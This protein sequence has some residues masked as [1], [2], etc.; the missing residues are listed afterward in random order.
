MKEDIKKDNNLSKP[1]DKGKTG[2]ESSDKSKSQQ[3]GKPNKRN[4]KFKGSKKKGNQ[5]SS[6]PSNDPSWYTINSEITKQV[7][8]IPFNVF[9]GVK[10][11]I[12]EA[13]TNKTQAQSVYATSMKVPGVMV[14]KY[15]PML[16]SGLSSKSVEITA[17]ALYQF[18]RHTNS[19]AKNYESA[20]LM[21]YILAM[22]SVYLA[23]HQLR[24]VL[25]LMNTYSLRNK[26]VPRA[27]L[28]A[29]ALDP[30]E[31]KN[32][33]LY[34]G[35]FNVLVA[36]ANSF[37]VPKDF[38]LFKRRAAMGTVVFSD[39]AE[40]PTQITVP[41]TDMVYVYTSTGYKTGGALVGVDYLRSTIDDTTS[42]PKG[43]IP[44]RVEGT[45]SIT[46]QL[47]FWNI[48]TALNNIKAMLDRITFDED[49]NIIAGDIMKA[50]GSEIF[51][52]PSLQ[53][54]EYQEFT[55]DPDFMKQFES[56][57]SLDMPS[58]YYG[59]NDCPIKFRAPN[60]DGSNLGSVIQPTICQYQ[61][62][63]VNLAIVDGAYYNTINKSST[64]A[65]TFLNTIITQTLSNFII[66][67]DKEPSPE[68]VV[69]WSRLITYVDKDTQVV[70]CGTE[71]VLGWLVYSER[72]DYG[73]ITYDDTNSKDFQLI[74]WLQ[75]GNVWSADDTEFTAQGAAVV[76][77]RTNWSKSG[78]RFANKGLEN[79][80]SK[81][82]RHAPRMYPVWGYILN[83]TAVQGQQLIIQSRPFIGRLEEKTALLS[84]TNVALIHDTAIYGLLAIPIMKK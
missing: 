76:T 41:W 51:T 8:S 61:S 32:F 54:D 74:Q 11:N 82:M 23:I 29:L 59:G 70:I 78:V 9:T 39:E 44:T 3:K 17:R 34:V 66:S 53:W 68:L 72:E 77:V 79:N 47:P 69:E 71:L 65:N 33:A 20:D 50:Y 1:D 6:K 56:S 62:K 60:A 46:H 75:F 22:D 63:F 48:Q 55:Y 57:V 5:R 43:Y 37:A 38:S 15:L 28:R 30:T 31:I 49:M 7:A 58:A 12:F 13:S 35:Q 52:L 14:M 67:T 83:E 19:G 42:I 21:M 24:R 45:D 16:N 25:K 84:P 81:S 4:N 18:V 80:T 27:I 36:R 40:S 2:L 26:Q 10:Y 64:K 73:G